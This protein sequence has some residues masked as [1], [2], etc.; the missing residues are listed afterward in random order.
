[1]AIVSES[2][3]SVWRIQMSE[4]S[5]EL[6]K[7]MEESN[8]TKANRCIWHQRKP[9]VSFLSSEGFRLYEVKS[10]VC[11]LITQ[12]RPL[13][14]SYVFGCMCWIA[15][16]ELILSSKHSIYK[17]S[18][19][20]TTEAVGNSEL[21]IH[22]VISIKSQIR[23]A[24]SI[25]TDLAAVTTDLQLDLI[26]VFEAGDLFES[27]S[28]NQTNRERQE[29]DIQQPPHDHLSSLV[30]LKMKTMSDNA[31]FLHVISLSH[32]SSTPLCSSPMA[33]IITPDLL[34]Y[35]QQSRH[36]LAGSNT[37]RTLYVY[38]LH[39]NVHE[40]YI[41]QVRRIELGLLERPKG[42]C[43]NQTLGTVVLVGKL[44]E[45]LQCTFLPSSVVTEYQLTIGQLETKPNVT[46]DSQ[47]TNVSSDE[48]SDESS[49]CKL[50][51]LVL[52]NGHLAS[53]KQVLV[54]EIGTNSSIDGFPESDM[55]SERQ[56]LSN[57][58]EELRHVR[59]LLSLQANKLAQIESR[60]QKLET[61][62]CNELPLVSQLPVV[63]VT[64]A[65]CDSSRQRAFLLIRKQLSLA[66][67][68]KAFG[69]EQI[70]MVVEGM[71]N[72]V[73]TADKDGF[74]PIQFQPVLSTIK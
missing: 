1:M 54:Q 4:K 26:N 65:S 6:N 37:F 61:K 11:V 46:I 70:A 9:I 55:P 38:T 63:Y 43:W 8:S 64:V 15:D 30:H 36:L 62:D 67:L 59:H 28:Q 20:P 2:Q 58:V 10:E 60:L 23:S 31:A 7:L 35:N 22:L 12:W 68:Q 39:H 25:S 14:A 21:P 27:T 40:T 57:V 33:G 3:I 66:V 29:I 51:D 18:L 5:Q 16:H 71:T 45:N 74:I 42:L 49:S 32:G 34:C 24:V 48:G 44:N 13:T 56:L 53:R 72:V 50:T 41:E 52:P 19:P 73:L 17:L 47:C 69:M